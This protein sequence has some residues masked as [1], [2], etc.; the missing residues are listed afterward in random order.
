MAHDPQT[1]ATRARARLIYQ[2]GV[3]GNPRA[4]ALAD[5][6]NAC[7]PTAP[8]Q[9]AACTTCGLAFQQAAV[10]AT[11]TFIGEPARRIRNRTTALTIVP[12]SGCLPPDG[13]SP[14]AF[15]RVGVEITTALAALGLPATLIA[16]E[17]SYNEDTTGEVE[18]HWSIHGHAVQLDWLSKA[19]DEALRA[20]FPSS[21][22]VMRPVKCVPL[23]RK[24]EGRRYPF[25]PERRRR[26]TFLNDSDPNRE[27]YRD[28]KSRPLRPPQAVSL[29]L[30]EHELGFHRRLLTHGID[31]E[32][33]RRHLE[34]L[35]WP[36]DGPRRL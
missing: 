22:L 34:G 17:A 6:L 5:V 13:F 9:S 26:V 36:R 10:S 4:A 33:V 19:Q 14:E 1:K 12:A 31:D 27:P 18:P 29:A 25:K 23:D 2:L 32:A 15:E 35:G 21:R 30:V 7:S 3:S 24:P 8:C 16:L 20:A 11:E 28:T